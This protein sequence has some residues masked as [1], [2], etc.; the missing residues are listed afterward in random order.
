MSQLGKSCESAR[1]ELQRQT[2]EQLGKSCESAGKE[3]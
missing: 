1:E 2:S 3:L